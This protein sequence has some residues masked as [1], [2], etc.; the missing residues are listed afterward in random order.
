MLQFFKYSIG[1]GKFDKSIDSL[2]DLAVLFHSIQY[3]LTNRLC[4][5]MGECTMRPGV[6][7]NKSHIKSR[8]KALITCLR[9]GY[10]EF[11]SVENTLPTPY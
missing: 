7:R 10:R 1:K 6:E 3:S 4:K 5:K 2:F 11:I 8:A 9:N